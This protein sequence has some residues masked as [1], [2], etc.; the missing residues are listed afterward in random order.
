MIPAIRPPVYQGPHL[1]KGYVKRTAEG[2]KNAD[3][4]FE[5]R[6]VERGF[7]QELSRYYLLKEGDSEWVRPKLLLRGKHDVISNMLT[8]F[9]S[10]VSLV[11]E[12]LEDPDNLTALLA[13]RES[14]NRSSWAPTSTTAALKDLE[15][16]QNFY[17]I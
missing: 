17:F 10:P 12:D 5:R 4:E 7:L 2:S 11:L 15:D 9:R 1:R 13:F 3:D 14:Y 16:T 8:T 6:N